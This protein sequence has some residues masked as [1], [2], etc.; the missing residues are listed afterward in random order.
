MN[1]NNLMTYTEFLKFCGFTQSEIEGLM[2]QLMDEIP[3]VMQDLFF[4][5]YSIV[6]IEQRRRKE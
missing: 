5:G 3:S 1:E 6:K 4:N 2:N